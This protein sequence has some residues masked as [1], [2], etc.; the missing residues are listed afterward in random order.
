MSDAS[1]RLRLPKLPE[2]AVVKITIALSPDL[3]DRLNEYARRYAEVYGQDEPVAELVPYII[4][5]FID[6]D[7]SFAKRKRP[8]RPDQEGS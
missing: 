5:K 8:L 6:D 3:T 4:R 7:R 1:P 2:R